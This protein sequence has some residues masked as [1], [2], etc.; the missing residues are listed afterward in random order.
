MELKQVEHFLA[1]LETGSLSRAATAV[2]LTQQALSKSLLR[3]EI[4][5]GG[6]VFERGP[7]GMIPTP[8]GRALVDQA[9]VVRAEA[10]QLAQLAKS[11]L[12]ATEGRIV[13]GLSPVAEAGPA[14][15]AIAHFSQTNPR[16]AVD[17][18][19]GDESGFIQ[20]ILAG[21]MDLA[22]S[23]QHLAADPL[24]E[25]RQLCMEEWLVIAR[26]GHPKLTAATSLKDLAGTRWMVGRSTDKRFNGVAR[27]FRASGYELPS[28]GL[29]STLAHFSMEALRQSDAVCIMPKTFALKAP[30]IM[31]KRLTPTPWLTPISL[32]TRRSA[33]ATAGLKPLLDALTKAYAAADG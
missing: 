14:S 16:L 3:L 25:V 19:G 4:Q 1:V 23:T 13:I 21:E 2:G 26:E 28:G 10:R 30:G 29:F 9:R 32:F 27:E 20:A 5:I 15:G 18:I 11:V 12:T 8:L 22:V 33:Q 6:P 7:K 17:V 31:A 24:I